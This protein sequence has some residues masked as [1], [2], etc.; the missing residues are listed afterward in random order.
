MVKLHVKPKKNGIAKVICGSYL[1]ALPTQTLAVISVF[2]DTVTRLYLPQ[3]KFFYHG[4]FST[5]RLLQ[6]RGRQQCTMRM[7][8]RG[9]VVSSEA[10][11]SRME[12]VWPVARHDEGGARRCWTMSPPAA[13][14]A[15]HA[16]ARPLIA[17]GVGGSLAAR[18]W[19]D[20]GG[21][22]GG[23]KRAGSGGSTNADSFG[24]R[25]QGAAVTP[26]LAGP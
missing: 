2:L 19:D 6:W 5:I 10:C 4:V 12:Q 13:A 3:C 26:G 11:P 18:P 1:R 24:A 15:L 16:A 9:S 14:K 21:G 22:G 7:G 20:I 25:E 17:P 23:D 8:Y